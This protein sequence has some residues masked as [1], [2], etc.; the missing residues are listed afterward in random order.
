VSFLASGFFIL[1][2]R[3]PEE[4]PR[5]AAPEGEKPSMLTELKEGL[6]FVLA[7]PNLRAQAGCTA[8]SNFFSS[9]AFS[10]ILVFAVREL[11]LSAGLIGLVLSIG[12]VGGLVA[13]LVATRLSS[14]FG[15]GPVTIVTAAF[16]GPTM[17]LYAVAPVG[18]AALP[19]LVVAQLLFGFT[20]VV[21]NIVQVSYRQA[22]CPPRLQGRMNSVM[23]FIVWG[24]I[25]LG[26]MAGGTLASWIGLRETIAVGAIGGSLAVLWIVFSP[27]RHLREMP[28][29]VDDEAAVETAIEEAV[30]SLSA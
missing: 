24:T 26:T 7:N 22:I 20:V 11:D 16:F 6:R 2:I 19:L 18:N 29:P 8:T 3:K 10:I 4:P 15:I 17:L 5:S 30:P 28:E 9:L 13:A 25:P 21:Y 14:R 12:A 27:Q 23:R 1:R